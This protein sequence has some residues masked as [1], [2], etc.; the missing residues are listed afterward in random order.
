MKFIMAE[1][2]SI[3][4]SKEEKSETWQ[5]TNIKRNDIK[6]MLLNTKK[7]AKMYHEMLESEKSG[8]EKLLKAQ[9]E[10]EEKGSNG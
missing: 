3:Q 2:R 9:T 4:M 10:K 8:W 5:K 6:K 1:I 7:L